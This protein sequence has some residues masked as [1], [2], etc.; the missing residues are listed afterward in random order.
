MKPGYKTTEFWAL[1][2]TSLVN[3]LAMNGVFTPDE[4]DELVRIIPVVSSGIGQAIIIV[5]YAISRGRIKGNAD[6]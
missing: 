3:L 2:F 6:T 1:I 4:S 5:G